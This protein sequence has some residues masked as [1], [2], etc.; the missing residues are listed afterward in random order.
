MDPQRLKEDTGLPTL[1][2]PHSLTDS[3]TRSLSLEP[4]RQLRSP[5]HLTVSSSPQKSTRV[6]GTTVAILSLQI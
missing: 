4:G 3:Q 2:L 6:P 1:A 5:S